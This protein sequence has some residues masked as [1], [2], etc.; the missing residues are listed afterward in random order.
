MRILITSNP[1]FGHLNG[2]LAFALA[3]SRAGHDVLVATG[4]DM[5]AQVKR[6]R[7]AAAAVGPP[8]ST[9]GPAQDWVAHF[10]ASSQARAADLLPMALNWAPD[11][12]VHEEAELA[13]AVAARAT[14]AR[15]VVH[16]LGLMPPTSFWPAFAPTLQRLFDRWGVH[17]DVSAVRQA[18]YLDG[19]PDAL[20]PDG[21]PM[22]PRRVPIRP[23]PGPATDA[24]RLPSA[25]D[26][27]PYQRTVHLTLGTVFHAAR[28]VLRSLLDGLQQ[29]PVNVVATTGPGTTPAT[30]GERPDNVLLARYLPHSLLLPRCSLVVSHGGAGIML[31]A[32]AHGLPQLLVPLGADQP[33]NAEACVRAGV[34]THLPTADVTPHRVSQT[35][36]RLLDDQDVATA[37][38]AV[39]DELR[40]RPGPDDV[41]Q[42]L[43]AA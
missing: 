17:D 43:L 26:R 2:M 1:L 11:M 4:P 3:A 41:V 22:W 5:V 36:T 20:R 33:M 15:H 31:G 18:T 37:T 42:A 16:G 9:D 35:V 13:G 6:H 12:V 24:D 28:D 14:G 23:Q 21:E 25:I 32:L 27:L 29:L 30:F 10:L 40:S 34:A 8:A 39:R 7:L 19:C 38:S